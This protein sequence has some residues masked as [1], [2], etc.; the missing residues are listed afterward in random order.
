MTI[1]ALRP[2][3]FVSLCLPS[4]PAILHES[5]NELISHAFDFPQGEI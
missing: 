5:D 3:K 4:D 2:L 1:F